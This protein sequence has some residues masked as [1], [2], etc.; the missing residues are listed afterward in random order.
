[1]SNDTI[2]RGPGIADPTKAAGIAD[3]PIELALTSADWKAWHELRDMDEHG[4]IP[5]DREAEW[6]R[7]EARRQKRAQWI[8]RM[9]EARDQRERTRLAADAA[10]EDRERQQLGDAM[11]DFLDRQRPRSTVVRPAMLDVRQPSGAIERQH[12]RPA[13][14]RY[15]GSADG[16]GLA[17]ISRGLG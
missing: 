10:P 4:V 2:E 15:R 5:A 3:L 17:R 1:M 9:T 12:A 7:L 8:E 14:P 6:R 16:A 13:A 11:R